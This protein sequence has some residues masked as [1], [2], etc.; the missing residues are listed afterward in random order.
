M[1]AVLEACT[2][3]KAAFPDMCRHGLAPMNADGR[4]DTLER[5]VEEAGRFPADV[6]VCRVWL[7]DCNVVSVIRGD[8]DTYGYKHEVEAHLGRWVSHLSFLVAVQLE[9]VPMVQSLD[10]PFAGRLPL[11][12]VRP[13]AVALG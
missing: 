9:G 7:R 12:L 11:G 4:P 10:R 6:T 5:I 13:G 1:S 8:Q 3:L 2:A